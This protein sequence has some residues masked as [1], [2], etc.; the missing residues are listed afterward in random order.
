MQVYSFA[1]YQPL[2]T[3]LTATCAV[4]QQGC[5]FNL[6]SGSGLHG[7]QQQVCSPYISAMENLPFQHS[8]DATVDLEEPL[9]RS[10]SDPAAVRNTCEE[11]AF[12]HSH[13]HQKGTGTTRCSWPQTTTA[14]LSLQL[15]W[16]L[17]LFPSAYARLGWI[18][19]LG[20]CHTV[21]GHL[22]LCSL[23]RRQATGKSVQANA[24]VIELPGLACLYSRG[25]VTAPLACGGIGAGA[26]VHQLDKYAVQACMWVGRCAG[27]GVHG[28]YHVQRQLR[29]KHS[30]CAD[31][32]LFSC[33]F[34]SAPP[35]RAPGHCLT[36]CNCDTRMC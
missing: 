12:A 7:S 27:A 1:P 2:F 36:A 22:L 29:Y 3:S 13:S 33:S 14:L 8:V 32:M 11:D 16:G 20:K 35:P 9:L 28:A 26:G 19:A 15:G 17:W 4:L 10:S 21:Y 34:C 18:P 31:F 5:C 25:C 23:D 24:A 6:N 30:H